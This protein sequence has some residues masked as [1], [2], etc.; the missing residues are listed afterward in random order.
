MDLPL[1]FIHNHIVEY[2]MQVTYNPVENEGNVVYNLFIIPEHE[3][4]YAISTL[5][6]VVSAG[7]MVGDMV[8]FIEAGETLDG[9]GIPE[10]KLGICTLC[11]ITLDGILLRRGIATNAIGGG[12]IEVEAN[13]PNRFTHIILYEATTFDPLQVMASQDLTSVNR[14]MREGNGHILGNIRECHMEAEPLLAEIL[15]ECASSHFSGILEV[16]MPNASLLGVS[17]S[18]QYMGVVAVGGTNPFAAMKE[19]GHPVT[20]LA[21]KG[22]MDCR[23]MDSIKSF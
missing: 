8:R 9:V 19:D 22:L 20:T 3:R 7:I 12:L 10:G 14:V 4:E 13:I 16:G 17:V 21:I 6:N 15:D 11:S 23:L 18:P 2:S 5:K 1:K